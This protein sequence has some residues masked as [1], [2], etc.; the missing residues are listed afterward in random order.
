MDSSRLEFGATPESVYAIKHVAFLVYPV[1][2]MIRAR[3]FYERILGLKVASEYQGHWVE[4]N[5]QGTML[6]VTDW[7][8]GAQPC[9]NGAALALEVAHPDA[10]FQFFES[11]RVNIIKPLFE[12]PVSRMGIVADPEGNGIVIHQSKII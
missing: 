5:I 4:Y 3:D 1:R 7:L 8:E 9:S 6:A 2:D 11:N 10:L 12:T